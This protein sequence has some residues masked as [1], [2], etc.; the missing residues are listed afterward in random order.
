MNDTTFHCPQENRKLDL[1]ACEIS[2]ASEVGPR[3][4]LEDLAFTL[5]VDAGDRGAAVA[6][7]LFDQIATTRLGLTFKRQ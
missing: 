3:Q 7:G 2:A 5:T 1:A 6:L 4:T